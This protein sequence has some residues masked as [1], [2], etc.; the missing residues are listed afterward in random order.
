MGWEKRP[1]EILVG[2]G[3]RNSIWGEIRM[4]GILVPLGK[5]YVFFGFCYVCG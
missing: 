4:R 5:D 3:K 2:C 1:V